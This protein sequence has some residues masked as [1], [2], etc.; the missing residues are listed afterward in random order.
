[1]AQ[2]S[3]PIQSQVETDAVVSQGGGQLDLVSLTSHLLEAESGSLGTKKARIKRVPVVTPSR[4]P[5][6]RNLVLTRPAQQ[7]ADLSRDASLV[8]ACPLPTVEQGR[9]ILVG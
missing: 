1:M 5:W 2:S 7:A 4:F 3:N 8:S 9:R 6:R